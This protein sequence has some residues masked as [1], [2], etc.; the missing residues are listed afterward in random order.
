MVDWK[1]H[2][3]GIGYTQ[4]KMSK[5]A[6]AWHRLA[7]GYNLAA[8]ILNEFGERIPGDTRPFAFNAA[9]SVE[10]IFKAI[11]AKKQIGIPTRGEGHELVA[12]C[13]KASVPITDNQRKTLDLLTSTLIWSGRYPAPNKEAKWDEYQDFTFE[14]HIVRTSIGNVH[15]ARANRETFP[16]WNNYSKIWG[17]CIRE[18]E[19]A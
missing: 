10:L 4:A 12:L 2:R 7:I 6:K 3:E 17:L 5:D 1:K 8:A 11:L 14:S 15:T 13:D 16:D 18:Y 19:A 9:L